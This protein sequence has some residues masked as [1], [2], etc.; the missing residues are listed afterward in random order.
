MKQDTIRFVDP[1]KSDFFQTLRQRV[2]HYFT[3]NKISRNA[4]RSMVVKTII[5][6]SLHVLPFL[7]ILIFPMPLWADLLLWAFMGIWMAGIGMSV[8]HDANHGS[9]SSN[10]KVNEWLAHSINLVGGAGFNWRLQHNILHHTYTNVD[11]KDEDI[12]AKLLLRFNPHI[13]R[14]PH[15]RLQYIYA[16][17]LYS[18]LT[19]YWVTAKDFIQFFNYTRNGTSNASP[20]KKRIALAKIIILKLVYFSVFFILPI[21]V[22]SISFW[23][24][25]IGFLVMHIVSGLI[26]SVIFQLAHTVEGTS[27]PL[28]NE[29]GNIENDWAIHQLNTTA[30]FAKRSKWLSWYVGGLNFQVEHHLFP[31]ICHIHYPAISEIVKKTA[32][33]YNIPYLE[34][35]TMI[36]AV[37]S[38]ITMLKH[39]GAPNINAIMD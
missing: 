17:F 2:E 15:H 19:L 8:M 14:K 21:F 25:L 30:N 33:E 34:N 9:Y 11:G 23:Q 24:V 38:H 28:P 22:A 31:R 39:F 27:Y 3:A 18:I 12:D 13:K 5:M 26:L 20:K 37:R 32:E 16:F 1:K 35:K 10:Q 6:I 7:A 36:A 29:T 4:D